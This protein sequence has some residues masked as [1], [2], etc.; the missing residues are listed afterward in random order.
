MTGPG[1]KGIPGGDGMTEGGNLQ[2][3]VPTVSVIK[4]ILMC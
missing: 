3:V 1:P 4:D 2:Q